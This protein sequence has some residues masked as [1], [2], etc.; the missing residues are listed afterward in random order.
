MRHALGSGPCPHDLFE[1][2]SQGVGT[3]GSPAAATLTLAWFSVV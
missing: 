1:A 2:Q 3:A